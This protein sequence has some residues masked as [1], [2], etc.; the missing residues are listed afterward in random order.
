MTTQIR[1]DRICFVC[2]GICHEKSWRRK[3]GKRRR[4]FCSEAHLRE[5]FCELTDKHYIEHRDY[6]YEPVEVIAR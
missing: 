1:G 4:Y 6:F 3:F 5:W 2:R